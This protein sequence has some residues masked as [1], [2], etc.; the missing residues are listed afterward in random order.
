[1]AQR[2]A[3]LIFILFSVFSLPAQASL[4]APKTT[5]DRFVPVNQAFAFDFRQN[6]QQLTLSGR[7][8]RAIISIASKFRWKPNTLPSRRLRCPQASRTKMSSTASQRF[9]PTICSWR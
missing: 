3:T 7:S 6:Q 8:S 5:A 1:M 4:F 2:I 9:T